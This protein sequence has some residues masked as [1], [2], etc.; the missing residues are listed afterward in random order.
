MLAGSAQVLVQR[1]SAFSGLPLEF[2][3]VRAQMHECVRFRILQAPRPALCQ[4]VL[5][6][7]LFL[8]LRAKAAAKLH[9]SVAALLQLFNVAQ[10]L[11]DMLKCLLQLS[12]AL[13][14]LS[15]ASELL[16]RVRGLF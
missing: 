16:H 7:L 6:E 15:V 5:L 4:Q 10:V 8:L 9:K 14:K 12:A 2:R 13:N 11:L 3:L 1:G